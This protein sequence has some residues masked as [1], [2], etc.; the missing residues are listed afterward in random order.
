MKKVAKNMFLIP[1]CLVSFCLYTA[2][3]GGVSFPGMPMD[4]SNISDSFSGKPSEQVSLPIQSVALPQVPTAVS[5]NIAQP[6][7][8]GSGASSSGIVKSSGPTYITLQINRNPDAFRTI[9][10]SFIMS[11]VNDPANFSRPNEILCACS[12]VD[13]IISVYT[14]MCDMNCDVNTLDLIDTIMN[15]VQCYF[16]DGTNYFVKYQGVIQTKMQWFMNQ[17]KGLCTTCHAFKKRYTG[18]H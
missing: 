11:S 16:V 6:V 15:E 8:S 13:H 3:F 12:H 1:G 4:E 7:V 10:Q 9:W 17:Y 18:K 14:T 5:C 2:A